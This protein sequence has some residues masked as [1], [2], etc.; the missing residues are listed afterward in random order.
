MVVPCNVITGSIANNALD[1][2]ATT[3]QGIAQIRAPTATTPCW[4]RR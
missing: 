2:S 1:F 3:L 4:Y